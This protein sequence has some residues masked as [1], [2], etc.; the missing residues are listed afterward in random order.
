VTNEKK[1]LLMTLGIAS[2]VFASP[3]LAAS[4]GLDT[5]TSEDLTQKIGNIVKLIGGWGGLSIAA[6]GFIGGGF[7]FAKGSEGAVK[8]IIGCAIGSFCCFAAWGLAKLFISQ[9]GG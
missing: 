2:V 4:S 5:L 1:K 3:V 9:V 6:V 7:K 8:F